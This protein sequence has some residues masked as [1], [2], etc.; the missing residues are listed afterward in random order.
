MQET[1]DLTKDFA[2]S[3]LPMSQKR[4]AKEQKGEIHPKTR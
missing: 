2:K 3:D 1:K 4:P